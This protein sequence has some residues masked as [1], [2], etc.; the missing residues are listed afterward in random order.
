MTNF[1]NRCKFRTNKWHTVYPWKTVSYCPFGSRENVQ[2]RFSTWLLGQSSWISDQNDFRYFWSTSHPHTSF[3]IS[4]QWAF[5]FR[6][7][8]SRW[9]L[10]GHKLLAIFDLQ[11]TSM[12]LTKFQV[13]W[14]FSSGEEGENRFS[15]WPPSWISNCNNLSHFFILPLPSM[16]STQIRANW[17]FHSEDVRNRFSRWPPWFF[18]F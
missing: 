17:P 4:S 7:W 16:L 13:N 3:Q 12:I 2:N 15:R 1:I 8:S 9:Q 6:R 5:L 10:W 18:Y 11:V 14:S